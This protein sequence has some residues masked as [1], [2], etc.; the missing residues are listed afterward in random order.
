MEKLSLTLLRAAMVLGLSGTC[1]ADP[2]A[3][4]GFG[5]QAR[6]HS[7]VRASG[8]SPV[9]C[10]VARIMTTAS[11]SE[12]TFGAVVIADCPTSQHVFTHEIGHLLGGQHSARRNE[13]NVVFWNSIARPNS[14]GYTQT[15][16]NGFRTLM[17]DEVV[18]SQGCNMATGCPRINR[19]SNPIHTA[20]LNGSNQVL[21]T[22]FVDPGPGL[23]R[24]TDMV[25]TLSGYYD[26]VFG[27]VWGGTLVEASGYRSPNY[28]APGAV[29]GLTATRSGTLLTANW[30]AGTGVVG[31]Y[32]WGRRTT[33]AGSFV[34][35]GKTPSAQAALNVP[36]TGSVYFSVAACNAAGCSSYMNIGPL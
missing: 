32:E 20:M 11:S 5:S 25:Q 15:A 14:F 17:G 26:P 36:S 10:G 34:A 24:T 13:T 6:S 1:Q 9:A 8:M 28:G 2:I 21:G 3:S 23:S 30:A 22:S 33:S 12:S 31:W 19:W 16:S 7:E 29:S 35:S 27:T 18:G 4:I